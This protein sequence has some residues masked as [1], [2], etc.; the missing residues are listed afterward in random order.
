MSNNLLT[1]FTLSAD[2]NA[3]LLRTDITD[4]AIGAD[5][6]ETGILA[7][8]HLSSGII[9]SQA[10]AEGGI[11][12]NTLLTPERVKQAINAL[13]PATQNA[14]EAVAG[15]G[16][17]ATL[18]NMAS[19]TILGSSGASLL[20]QNKY[21]S[22]TPDRYI[23]AYLTGGTNAESNYAIWDSV[24][25]GSCRGTVDGTTYNF[26]GM[27]FSLVTDMDGVASVVQVK[28][29]AI[30]G[31]DI[32]V[33][34]STN[35]FVYTSVNSTSASEVS[36]LA[37][38]TGVVGT[39]IS[40]VG[41]V[42]LDSE[43][44]Q[45]TAT[46]TVLD[47]TLDANMV[48]LINDSGEINYRRVP[49]TST[50]EAQVGTNDVKYMTA[51]KVKD[52]LDGLDDTTIVKAKTVITALETT[53]RIMVMDDS[54]GSDADRG[55]TFANFKTA[56]SLTAAAS[57]A[58]AAAGTNDTKYMTADKVVHLLGN[59]T[60]GVATS[61]AYTRTA[62]TTLV[63]ADFMPLGDSAASNI[64]KKVT[65]ANL[66]TSLVVPLVASDAEAAAGTN[67]TK[68]MTA[69]KTVH[70]LNNLTNGVATS[71]AYTRTAKTTPVDADFVLLGDSAAS[72]VDKKTTIANLK[73]ALSVVTNGGYSVRSTATAS[74]N[75]NITHGL[76]RI[77][78]QI[79]FFAQSNDT[80]G[81]FSSGCTD[82]DKQSHVT[83]NKL[84][85]KGSTDAGHCIYIHDGTN[86][87]IANVT[88]WNTSTFTL[89]WTKGASG[90]AAAFTWI[91][92]A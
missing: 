40:G 22:K 15:R 49:A 35:K 66:K 74:G 24:S 81:I 28:M 23:P 44:G 62:K 4:D 20:V 88:A 61:F 77:P 83:Y 10:Q 79:I 1:Q 13:A 29:R 31:T 2:G 42:Y 46:A 68:F 25:D 33:V 8:T 57:D 92:L 90:E 12:T 85:T 64:D 56:L 80:A 26:D 19:H 67:N 43:S 47:K 58:E 52:A 75:Q 72:N 38:S 78:K 27:D 91:A 59:L 69:D 70:L 63:D 21:V 37:T 73:T 32:T 55:I 30:T 86:S 41:T 65:I 39:D 9:S 89:T 5:E 71:L 87:Q 6:I 17:L 50:A 76:G 53:D 36:V 82:D 60:S 11:N 7:F 14:T 18:A 54:H 45:G 3:R 84:S 16:Q 48:P 34:W 51:A